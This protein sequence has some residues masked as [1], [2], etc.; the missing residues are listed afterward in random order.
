VSHVIIVGAGPAGASLAYLLARRGIEVTLLERQT[1]FEREFRGEG[2]M[3][4]GVDAFAQ[5]GLKAELDALPYGHLAAAELYRNGRRLLRFN[6]PQDLTGSA[7]PRFISQPEVLEMIVAQ[8]SRFPL[9]H[10]ERGALAQDLIRE[11]GRVAGVRLYSRD[12]PREVRGDFVVGADGRGSVLRRTS[13]LHEQR[14]PQGFDVV[15]CKVPMPPFFENGTL[16]R[17]YVGRG[18][19]VFMFPAADGRVQVAWIIEKGTFGEIHRQGPEAWI[20]DMCAH[21]SPD[22]AEHLRRCAS[23]VT[24]PFLLNVVSDRLERWTAPGL[25]LIGD[26][27]H[28]M[29]PV[30]AQGINIALRDAL[31]A[32]NHLVPVLA[33]GASAPEIDAAAARVQQKRLLEVS[34]IQKLQERPPAILFEKTMGSR[35]ALR[36]L[37]LL[38]RLGVAQRFA[39]SVVQR[40]AFGVSRVTLNV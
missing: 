39:G 11:N 29:S 7:G 18:H 35:L 15:W 6:M 21:V 34:T 10:M 30:G 1:D 9:F 16:V 12:H 26:A 38:V 3:P 17:V 40:F 5:M 20:A 28:P 19:F 2:L 24:Q 36:L 37:P 13:G 27:A 25:L 33:A 4:S 31:V 8:A 22:L 23:Q 14:F 32:A